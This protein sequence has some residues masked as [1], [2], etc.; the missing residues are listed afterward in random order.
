MNVVK[1]AGEAAFHGC[2]RHNFIKKKK[3]NLRLSVVAHA[4]GHN[5]V[6]ATT[7]KFC[8]N[9]FTFLQ[10]FESVILQVCEQ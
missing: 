10:S 1:N 3:C 9:N 7:Y 2:S 5:T 6:E 8:A 4:G